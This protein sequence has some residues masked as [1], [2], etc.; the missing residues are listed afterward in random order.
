ME[1]KVVNV[2]R[3]NEEIEKIVEII[4]EHSEID[5]ILSNKV[6]IEIEMDKSETYNTNIVS[7]KNRSIYIEMPPVTVGKKKRY[8]MIKDKENITVNIII[9]DG[10]F[11]FNEKVKMVQIDAPVPYFI[12]NFP[13]E[14]K[15]MQRRDF[16]R[17]Y[18]NVPI[19]IKNTSLNTRDVSKEKDIDISN[20]H[21]NT[22]EFKG[23]VMN[24]SG[25]GFYILALKNMEEGDLV[26]CEFELPDHSVY[27]EIIAEV[28]RKD[29]IMTQAKGERFGYGLQFVDI[30]SQSRDQI[31]NYLDNLEKMRKNTENEVKH[32]LER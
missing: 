10:V 2:V 26:I 23:V 22:K 6:K 4:R 5:K 20:I 28:R 25:G 32:L 30:K 11:S 24:M 27:K 9:G 13:T 17:I 29:I 31:A 12:I 1:G 19:N 18:L 8:I 3:N 7:I 21:E 16:Q 14:I 15:V